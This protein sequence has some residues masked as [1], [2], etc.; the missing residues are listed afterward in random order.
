MVLHQQIAFAGG[1]TLFYQIV[2]SFEPLMQIAVPRAWEGRTTEADREESLERH[3]EVAQATADRDPDMAR[4]AMDSH[5]A[6][7]IG[8][9]FRQSA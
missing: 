3:R 8:D 9:L 4:A 5:F 7:S 6:R 2:R 1:N